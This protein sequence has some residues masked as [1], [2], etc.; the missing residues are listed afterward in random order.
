MVDNIIASFASTLKELSP[1]LESEW[2]AAINWLHNNKMI[3]N[4]GKFQAILLD[5]RG[6]DNANIELKIGNEKSNRLHQ[7]SF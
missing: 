6:F 5:K 1:I 4:L 7:L 2:E 3:V